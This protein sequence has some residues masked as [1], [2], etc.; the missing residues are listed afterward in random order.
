MYKI[1]W[2]KAFIQSGLLSVLELEHNCTEPQLNQTTE[3][4]TLKSIFMVLFIIFRFKETVSIRTTEIIPDIYEVL[5]RAD[6]GPQEDR[7]VRLKCVP[8]SA[9]L[10]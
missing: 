2:N 10:I 4:R 8:A 6:P 3:S 1:H 9:H 7:S 5:T